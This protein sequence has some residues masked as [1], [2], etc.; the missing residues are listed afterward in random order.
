MTMNAHETTVAPSM[1]QPRG[2]R[3]R[4]YLPHFDG[5]EIPQ[6]VTFRLAGSVPAVKLEAWRCQL[7]HLPPAEADSRFRGRVEWYLDLGKGPT[8]LREPAVAAVVQDSLLF[9]DGERYRMYAWCIMPNHVHALFTPAPDIS[10]GKIM[11][12]WKSFSAKQ[13]NSILGRSG[14]FWQEEYFDRF[15]RNARHFERAEGY[16][17]WN[18]AKAGLCQAP[19]DWA[20]G[21]ARSKAVGEANR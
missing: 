14:T 13:A 20:F 15:I 10:L 19:E 21:S 5:G 11:H 4:G 6:A 3:S 2:W 7:A 16:I 1:D 18:P 9:F 12:S 8:Y 17:E